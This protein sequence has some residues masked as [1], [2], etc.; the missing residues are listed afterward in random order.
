MPNLR[1]EAS[2]EE[3]ATSA[4]MTGPN[5][6]N[7][8]WNETMDRLNPDV[9]RCFEFCSIFPRGSKLRIDQLVCM[10][11]AQGFIKTSC[12]TED[13]EDVAKAY[14]Q[15][16]VLSSFLQPIRTSSGTDFFTIPYVLHD[17]LDKVTR[18]YLRMENARSHMGEGWEGDV[19]RDIHHLFIQNYDRDLI[20]EKILG[21]ENL[22]TLI[23]YVVGKD[24]PIEE[25]VIESI[26]KRLTKLRVLAIAFSHEH[27]P[28]KQP[29][30]FLFPESVSQ[31]KYLRYL[32][33]RTNITCTVTLPATLNK[34]QHLQLLDFGD[35]GISEFTFAK[36]V[37][38]RHIF[39][40]R[41][42][43][44]PYVGRLSSL[45]TLPGFQVSN[46]QGCDLEQ[47]RDLKKL[48]GRLGI[49]GLEIINS[50]GQA[51]QANL[52]AKRLTELILRW[53]YSDNRMCSPEVQAEVLEG[54]CPPME[55]QILCLMNFEG[56][57][58]PDW[59]VGKHSSG[60]KY[61]QDLYIVYCRQPI[62]A[63]GLAEAFPHL[64]VLQLCSCSWDA[65]PDD[66]AHLTSL[67]Y[68]M[69]YGCK[70]IRSLPILP[71]SLEILEVSYCND[72]FVKSCQ[73]IGHPN[74]QKI[75]HIP[76]R[77][78]QSC[79]T[80]LPIDVAG[81]QRRTSDRSCNTV[82][83]NAMFR[84]HTRTICSAR[85]KDAFKI[86]MPVALLL[87]FIVLHALAFYSFVLIIDRSLVTS[88]GASPTV[89]HK[90]DR[91][92]PLVELKY[93]IY[94]V[95]LLNSLRLEMDVTDFSYMRI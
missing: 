5:P 51:L 79:K 8:F 68:M 64:R 58:Y 93:L 39:C 60:P 61:L 7:S 11:I 47:L 83:L 14:I 17:I 4:T 38:L 23:V 90:M 65:L 37:N 32:A 81:R 78:F 33:F 59:M 28:I 36:L 76:T 82:G 15:E 55:L 25:K 18:N 19:P 27:D 30:D 84:T 86:I 75:E 42:A 89:Q 16:L 73:T 2:S 52:A 62:N 74:W 66:M 9:R 85:E 34:L 92:W 63:S 3:N 50:K 46:E 20:T 26:C 12:A 67:K 94:C 22:C 21:L 44:L 56:S 35:G 69:I 45:Q 91:T 95:D 40:K 43:M 41:V 88:L 48:R 13:M 57:R 31:L 70:N 53:D 87:L 1:G 71:E 80:L 77:H 6:C 29:S 49:G 54:L 24:T 72:E 10:W